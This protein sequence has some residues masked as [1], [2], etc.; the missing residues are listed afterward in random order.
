MLDTK[1]ATE[2]RA[3]R[4]ALPLP[5]RVEVEDDRNTKWKEVTSLISTSNIGAGFYSSRKIPIGRLILLSLP[6]PRQMRFFDESNPQYEVWALV[7]HCH[8]R[9]VLDSSA[10]HV[11][12]AF[13]GK[14]S[15]ASYKENPQRIYKI[16]GIKD[17]GLWEIIED[18]EES[19]PR[20][21]PRYPIPVEVFVASLNENKDMVGGERTVTE[22]ISLGGAAVFSN[23]EAE[24][25]EYVK[26]ISD[27]HNFTSL[28]IVRNR[29]IGEDKLPRLHLEFIESQFPL[30]GID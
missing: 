19:A 16:C 30:D 22:N 21:N 17:G 20:K 14:F 25:G 23:L 18:G 27:R 10:Y 15:P 1:F 6:L 26:V 11:G 24:I 9:S 13:A 7:R 4:I 8:P 29:R 5:V 2:R 3:A 12:V 28:A